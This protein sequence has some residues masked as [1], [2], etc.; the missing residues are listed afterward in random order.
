MSPSDLCCAR[1]P[2]TLVTVAIIGAA[3]KLQ[4]TV[5]SSGGKLSLTNLPLKNVPSMMGMTR[6]PTTLNTT[7]MQASPILTL[8]RTVP[9]MP[10]FWI[11]TLRNDG[12]LTARMDANQSVS[13]KCYLIKLDPM[14]VWNMHCTGY[15]PSD[16]K[17][18]EVVTS[19]FLLTNR[20][21]SS[22]FSN[23]QISKYGSWVLF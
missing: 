10:T 18:T 1:L 11:A 12:T 8:S 5:L 7:R 13:K 23:R 9:M 15:I 19:S 3:V 2:S 16:K 17:P 20:E 4:S 22:G 21:M 6:F 14:A